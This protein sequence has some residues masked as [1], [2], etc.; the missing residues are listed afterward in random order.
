M[1]VNLI[2]SESDLMAEIKRGA[3]YEEF[4]SLHYENKKRREQKAWGLLQSIEELQG[5]PDVEKKMPLC[6]VLGA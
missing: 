3:P 5:A 1:A 2:N 4:R 6:R